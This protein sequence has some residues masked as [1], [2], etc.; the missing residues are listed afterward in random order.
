MTNFPLP[1]PSYDGAIWEP[2]RQMALERL[3]Q[4]LPAAGRQYAASR[5]FDLGPADRSNVSALSPWIRHRVITESEVLAAVLAAH[6]F[7]KAEK[8]V[9]EVFWR[10][11]FKGWMECHPDTWLSYRKAVD[12]L[13][14]QLDADGELQARYEQAVNGRTGIGCF[15]AWAHEL[16]QTG[17]LH[18]HT[19]MWFA[20]I[21]IFTLELPWQLGADFFYRH[22]LDGDPASNTLGWR[23]VAGLHTKGKTYLARPGNIAR[24]TNGRFNPAG[25]L[26]TSASP[27]SEDTSHST[28][29]PVRIESP[30]FDVRFAML[31]TE[32]DCSPE[33]LSLP[34][35]PEAIAGL[36]AVSDRS[37]LPIS[38]P[39]RQFSQGVLSDALAR[40]GDTFGTE[41][42]R[43][44]GAHWGAELADWARAHDLDTI[45]TA[46]APVGPA[47]E[48]LEK[49]VSDL[50]TAGVRLVRLRR[51]YDTL[52]WP[53]ATRGF[54]QL[55]RQIPRILSDLGL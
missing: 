36:S 47:A 35:R 52:C 5:N 14:L 49:A 2:D 40:A 24:Y 11:Y 32:E 42:T 17:Y 43:L 30:V 45:V 54:F 29:E 39:V 20:S 48:H 9:Q 4:F 53:H 38:T 46:Y 22:L 51:H 19:R 27:L 1:V 55:K 18:N 8:F 26:A 6:G 10:T 50:H 21:W 31:V 41:A 23:W 37:P 44:E 33:F 34:N 7:S 16:C 13:A 3:K 28:M 15:D 25:Q 12:K